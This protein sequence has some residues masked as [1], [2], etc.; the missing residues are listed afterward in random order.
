MTIPFYSKL[1]EV[2]A[3]S[4]SPWNLQ[5]QARASSR[6]GAPEMVV[7]LDGAGAG[8]VGERLP[9][10]ERTERQKSGSWRAGRTQMT[11]TER[12]R[13]QTMTSSF[14]LPVEHRKMNGLVMEWFQKCFG[15]QMEV[16]VIVFTHRL[17]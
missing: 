13:F 7:R 15:S 4:C 5:Y 9:Q 10:G 17:S 11:K 2:R 8:P 3:L 1:L 14:A 6:V 16:Y 12:G